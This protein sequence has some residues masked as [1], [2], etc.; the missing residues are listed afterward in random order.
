MT[1]PGTLQ[2]SHVTHYNQYLKVTVKAVHDSS[3]RYE[4]S[5]VIWD[6]SV[7]PA[8]RRRRS[9]RHTHSRSWYSIYRIWM[10]ERLS[11]PEVVRT[12]W[13]EYLAQGYDAITERSDV[14]RGRKLP[15]SSLS[16]AKHT[17]CNT[18]RLVHNTSNSVYRADT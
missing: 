16:R 8:T 10:D 13:C 3:P 7:L 14:G 4:N 12:L 6:H 1:V 2:C 17:C 5:C 18:L 9:S 15:E 11:L